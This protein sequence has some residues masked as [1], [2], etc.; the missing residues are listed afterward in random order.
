MTRVTPN[1]LRIPHCSLSRLFSFVWSKKR[2]NGVEKICSH[3][4]FGYS[5][6]RC[7]SLWVR[8]QLLS[9]PITWK[10]YP[11]SEIAFL[12]V[13]SGNFETNCPF[14]RQQNFSL[15]L[16]NSKE[17]NSIKKQH[18]SIKKQ[19]YSIKMQHYS[20]K[21]QHCSIKMRHYTALKCNITA[22]KNNITALKSNITAVK[23]NIATLKSNIAALKS[24]ITTLKS[25]IT[26]L[27]INITTLKCNITTLKSNITAL[28]LP[29]IIIYISLL[30]QKF[31]FWNPC[32]RE[33]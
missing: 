33:F 1:A 18:Y 30:F 28:Q 32:G 31:R 15:L 27:K 7:N 10:G 2:R 25:N 14:F 3:P 13:K 12:I 17:Y 16:S 11:Y 9:N 4:C 22:L 24:N 21:K 6:D 29:K 19:H 23:C 20:I 8:F 26:A 5:I